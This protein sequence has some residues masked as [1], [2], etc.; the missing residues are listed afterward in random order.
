MMLARALRINR[1]NLLR[2]VVPLCCHLSSD[3]CMRRRFRA[4]VY[5]VS[6][7]DADRADDD[8]YALFCVCEMH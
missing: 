2:V 7:R 4:E 6:M 5:Q 1:E 8:P 3:E